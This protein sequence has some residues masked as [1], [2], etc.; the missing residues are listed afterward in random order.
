MPTEA[1]MLA[2]LLK[3]EKGREPHG[4]YFTWYA[5]IPVTPHGYALLPLWDGARLQQ[6][7]PLM[8]MMED[9]GELLENLQICTNG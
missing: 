8:V 4:T 3:V 6:V 5:T 9:E 2:D 1:F 7:E